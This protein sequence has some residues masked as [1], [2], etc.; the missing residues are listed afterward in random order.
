LEE[1]R[2]MVK[3]WCLLLI[4]TTV[5]GCTLASENSFYDGSETTSEETR[6]DPKIRAE[7]QQLMDM[8]KNY[9]NRLF[10]ANHGKKRSV[11]DDSMIVQDESVSDDILTDEELSEIFA[12]PTGFFFQPKPIGRSFFKRGN[13]NGFN[14]PMMGK[15][16]NPNGFN[17]PM[18]GKR[19]NPN[20]FNLLIKG[21]R[22]NPN[23]FN[24]LIKGKRGNPNGF[25]LP[26][27]LEGKRGNPNGFNLP[28]MGKRGNP[29]GFN[30]PMMGKRGNPNGFNLP[31]LGKR[32]NPNGFNLPIL[33]GKRL[34]F[35]YSM[36]KRQFELDL[37]DEAGNFFGQRG[38]RSVGAGDEETSQYKR[39]Y[40]LATRG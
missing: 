37:D 6:V 33:G 17:L 34:D 22:G 40:L 28:M 1:T 39:G 11:G 36:P 4:A 12:M 10:L 31:I 14:L 7:M 30:L 21:K 20:G 35:Y 19:G 3:V 38:K 25:N 32:G 27:M 5:A 26:M 24:L 9:K 13:P 2:V 29:N 23:G 18:M 8:M 16:G 15:R